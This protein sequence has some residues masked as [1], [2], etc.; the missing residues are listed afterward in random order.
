YPTL[1]QITRDYLVI[2][3]SAT[4]SEHAFSSGGITDSAQRKHLWP[5]ARGS[6]IFRHP[7]PG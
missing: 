2:Q 3:G 4:P 7:Y 1:K 6:Q 5:N